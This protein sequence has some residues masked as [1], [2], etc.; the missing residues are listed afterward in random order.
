[1]DEQKKRKLYS[2]GIVVG[3]LLLVM[4]FSFMVYQMITINVTKTKIDELNE[5]IRQL[6]EERDRT[7]ND[8]DLWLKNWKI[9]EVAMEKGWYYPEDK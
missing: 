2:A 5:Q 8:I 4:L 9:E 6:E 1:M 7:E 3:I